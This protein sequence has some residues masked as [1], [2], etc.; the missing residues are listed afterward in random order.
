VADPSFTAPP[1]RIETERL[2]IRCWEP[3]DAHALAE[4]VESSLDHLRA[5]MPWGHEEPRPLEDRVA[6]LRHFRGQFDLDQEFVYGIFTRDE[7]EV[8]GGTGLHTRRGPTAFEIGYWIRA[9]RVGRGLAPE[10]V[11]AVTRVGFAVPGIDRIEIR[12][13][14]AN[15]AS[16]GIP[17]KLGYVEEAT[18]HRRL[19]PFGSQQGPRD[20]IVFSLFAD[21]FPGTPA[22]NA[23][24]A[25]YDAAGARLRL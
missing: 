18:L 19:P 15:V 17:R 21:A 24:L 9:D 16:Q 14:P 11:A 20:V 4:A 7:A 23:E 8:V 25:A 1:Y 5:W 13:D 12:V 6:L 10:A 3:R 2:V 22:A